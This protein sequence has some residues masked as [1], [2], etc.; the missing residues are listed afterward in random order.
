MFIQVITGRVKDRDAFDAQMQAWR[1][2]LRPGATGFLGSTA[3]VTADDRFV[4]MARFDS[5]ESAR[6]NS[7]R[8][9][10]GAWWA[11]TTPTIEGEADF[12]DCAEVDLIGGGGSDDAGFVQVMQGRAKDPGELRRVGREFESQMREARPDV[13]GSTCAWHGDGGFT[14]AVYFTSEEAA[15]AGE[16]TMTDDGPGAEMMSMIDGEMV[17]FDLT[18]PIFD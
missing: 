18:E 14:Q 12:H 2:E 6:A 17:F 5:E 3:G 13:I 4:V 8:P 16:A 1:T 11:A 9:E 7:Q 15:R 10:Q